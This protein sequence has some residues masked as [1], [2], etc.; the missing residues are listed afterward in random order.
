M[1]SGDPVSDALETVI[2]RFA[3]LVRSVARRHGLDAADLDEVIQEV[4]FRI[5]RARSDS[6]DISAAQASYVYRT[7]VSAALDLI[8]QRR[9]ADWAGEHRSRARNG[10]ERSAHESLHEAAAENGSPALALDASE[11]ERAVES[12]VSRI[13]ETRRAVVRLYLAGHSLGEIAHVMQWSEPKTRSLLYRGL[14]GVRT[15]LRARGY[16]PSGEW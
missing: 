6:A 13:P 3:T 12:A 16:G 14:A 2:A 15:E 11:L 1:T 10:S 7:A 4:R 8:R 9:R 5:W